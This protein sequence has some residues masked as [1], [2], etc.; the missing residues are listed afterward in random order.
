M[1]SVVGLVVWQAVVQPRY[2][3]RLACIADVVGQHAGMVHVA[4]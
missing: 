2:V 3:Q 1:H 4:V